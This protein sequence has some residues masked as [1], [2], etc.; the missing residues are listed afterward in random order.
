MTS[1]L[2]FSLI[3]FSSLFVLVDPI[4][5]IPAF[6]VMTADAGRGQRRRMALRASITC[7]I[8]LTVFAFSGTL[9]FKLFG[10]TL[11]AFK[12]A[13]GFI[14]GLIALDMLQAKRSPTK[15]TPGETVEGAEKEDVGIVPLG[16]PM[17]AGPGAI[18]S[19][20]VLTTQNGDWRHWV[21]IFS[22]IVVVAAL[23]FLVLAA[24]ERVGT[25]LHE[26]GIRIL[27]RMMGLLLLS[28][29]VQFVLTGL[30]DAGVVR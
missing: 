21:V 3:A 2:Q 5:A 11:P 1:I 14:L 23:S 27:T 7:L 13:G 30:R 6:L 26:T 18:S 10:I 4:A 25:Y 28:I 24:A 29:A 20:I 16:I 15:E 22:A 9:I 19:V 17:L 8:V 12:I